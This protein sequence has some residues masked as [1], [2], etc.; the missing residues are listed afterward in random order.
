[1]ER[2]IDCD[3]EKLFKYIYSLLKGKGEPQRLSD[4][5]VFYPSIINADP[6][7]ALETFENRFNS[8]Q[9][10][11]RLSYDKYI[12]NNDLQTVIEG[13]KLDTDSFFLLALFCYDY[14]LDRCNGIRLGNNTLDILQDFMRVLESVESSDSEKI[15]LTLKSDKSKIQLTKGKA[16][17]HILE[18]IKTGYDSIKD[19][20]ALSAYDSSDV[21]DMFL[22]KE[23]SNSVLIWYCAILMRNF[24]ELNP[25]FRGESK[26]YMGQSLSINLLISNLIYELGLSRNENFTFS[27]ETLKGFFK[28]YKNKKIESLG[29]I[30]F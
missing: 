18:W 30:Y 11:T 25:Q 17:S 23:E 27:D 9:I 29:D 22:L 19:K 21:E 26:K 16:L 6:Q 13:L 7:R 3:N 24:F 5:T 4:G 8:N 2:P 12:S 20:Q 28:Q 10:V 1:M 14:A 15:Q